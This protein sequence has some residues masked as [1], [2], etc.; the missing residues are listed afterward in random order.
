[1]D[2][3]TWNGTSRTSQTPSFG[4]DRS[5]ITP[6]PARGKASR[7]QSRGCN[8]INNLTL[9]DE[10]PTDFARVE[11][12]HAG[13]FGG[14]REVEVVRAIRGSPGY[15]ANRSFVASASGIGIVGHLLTSPVGLQGPDGTVRVITVI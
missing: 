5:P 15:Q 7:D 6:T 13:A 3:R 4:S 12:I 10:R 11:A 2:S 1:M 9:R 8:V 14:P